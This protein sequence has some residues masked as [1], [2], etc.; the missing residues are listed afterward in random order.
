MAANNS[1]LREI[2]TRLGLSQTECAKAL[3]VSGET[4]RAWDAGRRATPAA[5]LHKAETLQ[6]KQCQ[7]ELMPLHVLADE[8]DV[9][10]RTLRAAARDGRLAATF[11]VRPFFGKL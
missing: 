9:H 6:P 7:G 10:V 2:R 5:I 1:K 8:F 11:D 4:L 3:R